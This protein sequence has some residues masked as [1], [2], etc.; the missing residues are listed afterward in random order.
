M[1]RDYTVDEPTG[2]FPNPTL[3]SSGVTVFSTTSGSSTPTYAAFTTPVAAIRLT[4][5]ALSS[6]AAKDFAT[7]QQAGIG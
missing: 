4:M 5:N 3:G 1:P 7:I 6:T 2:T